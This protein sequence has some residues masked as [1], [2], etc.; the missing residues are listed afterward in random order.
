MY[1]FEFRVQSL[2]LLA[3]KVPIENRASLEPQD[4]PLGAIFFRIMQTIIRCSHEFLCMR[5]V[6]YV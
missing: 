1:Y 4:I 5:T 3:Q 6:L 2:G